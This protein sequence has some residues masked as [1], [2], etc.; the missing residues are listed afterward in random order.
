MLH[1]LKLKYEYCGYVYWGVKKFE[2]RLN[3]REYKVGDFIH[4]TAV[5]ND[6]NT[7]EHS[8]NNCYYTIGYVLFDFCGLAENYV[9]LSIDSFKCFFDCCKHFQENGINGCFG[10][11]GSEIER[12]GKAINDESFGLY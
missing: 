5:D 4:F 2:I 3:D 7:V 8:I 12:K 10:C 9:A 11:T 6:G 1:E